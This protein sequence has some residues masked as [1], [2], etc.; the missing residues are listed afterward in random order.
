[1]IFVFTSYF[2]KKIVN[3]ELQVKYDLLEGLKANMVE[4][5]TLKTANLTMKFC[6]HR[7]VPPKATVSLLPIM[8]NSCPE[9]FS[10]IDYFEVKFKNKLNKSFK[11]IL[12]FRI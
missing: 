1:M 8:I 10:T 12:F 3:F 4:T 5:N 6:S 2:E 7:E 9:D 11:I